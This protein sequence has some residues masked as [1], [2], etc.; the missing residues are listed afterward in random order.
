[1]LPQDLKRNGNETMYGE[2]RT[3]PTFGYKVVSIDPESSHGVY[4]QL[5]EG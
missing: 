5:A 2:V 4:F 3:N 1:M